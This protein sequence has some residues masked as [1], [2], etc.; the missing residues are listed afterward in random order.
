MVNN[1]EDLGLVIF[2]YKSACANTNRELIDHF[3][4]EFKR[5]I[6]ERFESKEDIDWIRLIRFY[7][8]GDNNTLQLFK[9]AFDSFISSNYANFFE[10]G[11]TDNAPK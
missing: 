2:G 6:N 11:D 3:L 9:L 7:G 1:I 4:D 10:L 8:V 5:S